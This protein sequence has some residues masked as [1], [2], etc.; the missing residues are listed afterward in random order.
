MTICWK[1]ER[2]FVNKKLILW[3]C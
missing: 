1:I 3:C 2:K